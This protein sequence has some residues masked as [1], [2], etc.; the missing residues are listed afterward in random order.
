MKLQKTFYGKR[1][2]EQATDWLNHLQSCFE[3]K[4]LRLV[5][6]KIKGLDWDK[7]NQRTRIKVCF[8]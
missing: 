6:Y 5:Q 4:S 7:Q 2:G 8:K 3:I 1:S